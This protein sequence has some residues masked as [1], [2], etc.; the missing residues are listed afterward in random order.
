MAGNVWEWGRI[1][2]DQM[3]INFRSI[4]RILLI[5]KAPKTAMIRRSPTLLSGPNGAALFYV[6]KN[7]VRV[8]D[9]VVV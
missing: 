6:K 4:K 9:P 5:P 8:I 3:P 1:F 7:S 2:I